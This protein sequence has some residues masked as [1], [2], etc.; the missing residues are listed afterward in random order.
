MARTCPVSP[1]PTARTPSTATRF[2]PANPAAGYPC[3]GQVGW[4]TN[5]EAAAFFEP[6]PCYAWNN[7]LNGRRAM[8]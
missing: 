2:P 1:R 6:S 8:E 5:V 3:M 4:A 7:T